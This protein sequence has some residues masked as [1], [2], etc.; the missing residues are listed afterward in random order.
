MGRQ[1][2]A[3]RRGRGPDCT[4][5]PGKLDAKGR[6][7]HVAAKPGS[8][9]MTSACE[10]NARQTQNIMKLPKKTLSSQ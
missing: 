1:S 3:K 5:G 4:C 10:R 8:S 2:P 6:E 7:K 9:T